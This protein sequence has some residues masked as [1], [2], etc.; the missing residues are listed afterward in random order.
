MKN[1]T[2]KD[3][4]TFLLI[5]LFTYTAVDK[6]LENEKFIFQMELAPVPFMK[7]LAP[8]FGWFIPLAEAAI[9]LALLFDRSRFYG[10]C[11][12]LLLLLSFEVY[13]IGMLLSGKHLPCACGGV[14]A[15]MSWGQHIFFNGFF[16]VFSLIAIIQ[17]KKQ[18]AET[19]DTPG[20]NDFNNIL[21]T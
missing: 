9:V 21:H 3:L 11:A 12:S 16:I 18:E 14:I 8:F 17:H 7:T 5:L 2:L 20:K 15:K 13:I 1:I 10:L 19:P 6:I 4:V